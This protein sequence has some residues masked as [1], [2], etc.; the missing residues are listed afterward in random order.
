MTTP[1][2]NDT[3]TRFIHE[4]IHETAKDLLRDFI[5]EIIGEWEDFK[6]KELEG[7]E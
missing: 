6:E 4:H 5:A 3:L 1:I 2:E 7:G